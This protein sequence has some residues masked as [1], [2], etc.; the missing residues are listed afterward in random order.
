[1]GIEIRFKDREEEARL[2]IA[3]LIGA[4]ASTV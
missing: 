1:V 4:V 3:V 2:P